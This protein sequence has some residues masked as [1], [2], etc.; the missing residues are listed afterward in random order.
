M[1]IFKGDNNFIETNSSKIWFEDSG[2]IKI[3]KKAGMHETLEDAKENIKVINNIV[4][5]EKHGA[6]ID[7][8]KITKQDD[9]AILHY[10]RNADSVNCVALALL[11]D[12]D[13]SICIAIANKYAGESKV[14]AEIFKSEIEAQKWITSKLTDKLMTF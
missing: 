2:I 1:S 11:V 6:I 13:N 8:R 7:L 3:E 10:A 4:K 9:D 14:V 12:S 5:G